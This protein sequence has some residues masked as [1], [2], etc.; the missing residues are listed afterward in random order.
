MAIRFGVVGTN[1]RHIHGQV[2]CVADA[3]AS[4]VSF[5]EHDPALAE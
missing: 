1:H 4:C 2:K 3:G 5:Y